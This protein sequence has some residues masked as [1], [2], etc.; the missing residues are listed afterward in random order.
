MDSA[1]DKTSKY[2]ERKGQEW[3][4][5]YGQLAAI[6]L[7]TKSPKEPGERLSEIEQVLHQWRVYMDRPW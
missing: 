2:F 4:A 7:I 1:L 3:F 5:M 6:E